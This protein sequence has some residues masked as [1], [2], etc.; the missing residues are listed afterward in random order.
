MFCPDKIEDEAHFIFNC[1]VLQHL[2]STYIDPIT[3][4]ITG[5]E[6]FPD[7]FK[8]KAVMTEVKYDSCKYIAD[9]MDLR[10]YL[11][12]KPKTLG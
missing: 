10:N 9:A 3:S 1:S 11:H 8:L 4:G 6:F 5:F 7:G 12:S 2:R